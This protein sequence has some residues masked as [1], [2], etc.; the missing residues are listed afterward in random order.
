VLRERG[1]G[2]RP[3]DGIAHQLQRDRAIE[4]VVV[5]FLDDTHPAFAELA[6]T[7]VPADPIN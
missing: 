7:A 4:P 6:D 2:R 5:R 1:G 3:G